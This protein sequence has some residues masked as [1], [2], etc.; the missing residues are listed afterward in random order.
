MREL[1]LLG[2]FIPLKDDIFCLHTDNLDL[3]LHHIGYHIASFL[4]FALIGNWKGGLVSY[5]EELSQEARGQ[6]P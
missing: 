6:P 2:K 5:L 3:N 1:N 4:G